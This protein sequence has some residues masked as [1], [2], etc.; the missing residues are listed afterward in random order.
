MANG[1][2]G[3]PHVAPKDRTKLS[4]NPAQIRRRL[5]RAGEHLERDVDMYSEATGFKPVVD[6][7]LDEL[8]R[9]KPRAVDGSFRG[10]VPVWVTPLITREAKRRLLDESFGKL[11]GHVDLACTVIAKLLTDKSV[12]DHG[13]PIVDARTKFAAAQFV[14]EHVIGKPKAVVEIDGSDRVAQFLA[15]ALVLESG[16]PAH[17]VIDGQFTTSE[18]GEDDDDDDSE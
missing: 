8:A 3:R 10:G 6:W 2:N 17:P 15:S 16:Q 13:K 11:A 12:D 9:G 1:G 18:E 14:I 4:K 5:R 7:D